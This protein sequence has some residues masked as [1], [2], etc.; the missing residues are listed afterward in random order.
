M[1]TEVSSAT[2]LPPI[3]TV[4]GAPRAESVRRRSA[5]AQYRHDIWAADCTRPAEIPVRLE[6][7][8]NTS[9][10]QRRCGGGKLT[11]LSSTPTEKQPR[12]FAIDPRDGSGCDGGEV[13][14]ISLYAIDPRA[15]R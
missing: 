4:P 6:R 12:G 14:T 2:A 11:Y 13:E 3:R 1:L 9:R 15:A 7:T 5:A 10:V 8:S